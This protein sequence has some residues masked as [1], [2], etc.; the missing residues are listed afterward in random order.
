MSETVL[1]TGGTGFVGGWCIVELLRRGY[2]V[3][4]TLRSPA[5]EPAVRAAVARAAGATEP[6][7]VRRRRSDPRRGLGGRGRRLRRRAPRRLAARR[8]A[9]DPD[10]AH[11]PAHGHAPRAARRDEGGRRARRDDLGRRGRAP[12][13]RHRTGSATR[14]CGRIRPIRTSTPTAA[15]RSSPSARRGTSWRRAPVPRPSRRSSRRRVRPR[16]YAGEPRLGADRRASA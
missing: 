10:V 16:A 13:A 11:P 14:R 7:R 5:K 1:V 8:R 4:T 15:R 2:T 12:A 6:P 9:Q 3:R